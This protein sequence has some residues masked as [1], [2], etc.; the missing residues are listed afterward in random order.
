MLVWFTWTISFCLHVIYFEWSEP[1]ITRVELSTPT[2]LA[3]LQELQ[4]GRN[5]VRLDA[6]GGG[7]FCEGEVSEVRTVGKYEGLNSSNCFDTWTL[8]FDNNSMS[9]KNYRVRLEERT[10]TWFKRDGDIGGG[11]RKRLELDSEE[12]DVRLWRWSSNKNREN[13]MGGKGEK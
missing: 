9:W 4:Q 6:V 1:W 5:E 10:R 7:P 8:S 12:A 13:Y 11:G 2:S 3:L